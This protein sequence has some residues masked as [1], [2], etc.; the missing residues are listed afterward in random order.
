ML[1]QFGILRQTYYALRGDSLYI[2][3]KTDPYIMDCIDYIILAGDYFNIHI[4]MEQLEIS[5]SE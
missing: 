2:D 5:E 4:Y 3:K 1:D